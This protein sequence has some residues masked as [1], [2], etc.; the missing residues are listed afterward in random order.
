MIS[1]FKG[2]YRVMYDNDN[3]INLSRVLKSENSTK[4]PSLTRAQLLDDSLEMA[5]T[6]RLV[7]V[8]VSK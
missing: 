3:W 8:V 1:P 6:G 2:Y 7:S 5:K 4:I